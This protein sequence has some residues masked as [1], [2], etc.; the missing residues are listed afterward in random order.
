MEPQM[1]SAFRQP[2]VYQRRKMNIFTA[3]FG[4]CWLIVDHYQ[5]YDAAVM[6]SRLIQIV[7]DKGYEKREAAFK[8][9]SG[10]LSHDYID[11][12][13]ALS[14][15]PDLELAARCLMGCL[16]E[17]KIFF[18]A[19]GG[20]TM[21]ADPVSHAVALL[22]VKSWFSVRKQ[23]KAHGTKQRIEG[24]VLAENT[25]VVLVE[26]TVS[27]GRSLLEALDVLR[28]TNVQITA[29]CSLLD[30]SSD[31]SQRMEKEKIPY[32]SL[33]TYQDLGIDPL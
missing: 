21:G 8:L 1:M 22:G 4:I 25:K 29:L 13:R 27:T 18:D 14:S 20:M 2:L 19:I 7:K 16:D 5:S 9:S 26:D 24:A 6:K 17:K 32:L 33:I 10:G 30:R 11:M 3:V 23:E 12:R 31:M 28:E 15:G